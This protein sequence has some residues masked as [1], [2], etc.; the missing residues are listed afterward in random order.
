MGCFTETEADALKT[1]SARAVLLKDQISMTK[2]ALAQQPHGT[3]KWHVL[4]QR[5]HVLRAEFF[6]VR[7][8]AYAIRDQVEGQ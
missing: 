4:D 3:L 7:D 5:Y 6:T 2:Q 8:A 1:L